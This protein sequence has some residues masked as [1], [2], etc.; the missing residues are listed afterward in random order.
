M[1]ISPKNKGRTSKKAKEVVEEY[2]E[3]EKASGSEQEDDEE[4]G[5]EVE[6]ILDAKWQ[7]NKRGK[8]SYFVRWKGY[9]PEDDLWIDEEDAGGAEDLV[10]EYHEANNLPRDGKGK[11]GPVKKGRPSATAQKKRKASVEEMDVDEE[12]APKK[13]TK[14]G[15]PSKN[16][17]PEPKSDE[18]E[19]EPE[20]ASMDDYMKKAKWND[21][22]KE[23]ETVE[24]T[25]EADG[26]LVALV[27]RADGQKARV[28]TTVLA[29]RCPQKLIA[30]YET[31]LK[32]RPTEEE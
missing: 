4:E 32:W 12:E 25:G 14:R 17:E 7:Y 22:I 29:E 10:K 21:L 30:F 23:I 11:K 8:W 19:E 16:K 18:E 24:N 3:E 26:E 15:R 1:A 13:Q 27:T 5:Y 6:A 9:G 20:F 31:H 28:I 2:E